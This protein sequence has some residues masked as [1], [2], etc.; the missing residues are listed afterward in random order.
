[1]RS[2]TVHSYGYS[3]NLCLLLPYNCCFIQTKMCVCISI[4]ITHVAFVFRLHLFLFS[5]A[6]SYIIFSGKTLITYSSY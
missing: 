4:P 5:E 6:K 2:R 1:M 3:S